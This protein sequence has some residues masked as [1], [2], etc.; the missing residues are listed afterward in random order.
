MKN[1]IQ[2]LPETL[3]NQ[4][5]AGEVVER[6]ASVVK[7]L[8]ENAVDAGATHIQV[9]ISQAGRSS[10]RIIDNGQGMSKEDLLL[11][12]ERHATSKI[13]EYSD[14]MALK[15]M[16]FRGEALPS[17][18]AV[19]RMTITTVAEGELS[20][21]RLEI[22]GGKK[23]GLQEI[24]GPAGSTI[25]VVDLFY[26][27]PARMAF[28]KSPRVEWNQ[29][30]T[31]LERVALGFPLLRFELLHNGKKIFQLFPAQEVI[32]R[33][34]DLWGPEICQNLIPVNFSE[35]RLRITGFISPPHLHHNTARYIAF[36][37]N[38]RW[39][40]SPLLYPLILRNYAGMLPSGRF[41]AAILWLDV[42][43]ELIDINIHPFKQ[44]VRF[45][46]TAWIQGLTAKALSQAIKGHVPKPTPFV[47]PLS[48][49]TWEDQTRQPLLFKESSWIHENT[50]VFPDGDFEEQ[51][52][53]H[54]G[55][56]R[57][58]ERTWSF[59]DSQ[60]AAVS[61]GQE[62]F[63]NLPIIAQ[64][65]GTYL[66][67]SL[68]RGLILIDQHA[69]HERVLF[70]RFLAQWR[71][72]AVSSQYLMIPV[73]I[74][75]P[76]GLMIE[77]EVLEKECN[78]LGFEVAPAGGNNVWLKSIPAE[79]NIHQ[80][81][82]AFREIL[83]AMKSGK[84]ADNPESRIEPLVK[85]LACHSAIRA[86]QTLNQEE[87]LSLLRQLD[88]TESPSH[89]PHGRPLWLLISWDELEKRFKRK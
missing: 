15:T 58:T 83:E 88:Q 57:E 70:E 89:C 46:Q 34:T 51:N 43:P 80:A 9:E 54:V 7:E 24:A 31:A 19:S 86:G 36:L 72:G 87:I 61:A 48:T 64:L 79:M 74:E 11:A 38:Q 8:L 59:H 2:L 21:H 40:R 4:I 32:L 22:W 73:L 53:A 18:A 39:V 68:E 65:Q 50:P 77:A 17:I 26:N 55:E 42:P 20:G 44:E 30:Q 27:T 81:E 62:G 10:I 56:T 49:S 25:D 60:G 47:K 23:L 13:K 52:A 29:I 82:E 41:P 66:L 6:P 35:D 84:P 69:A 16:G 75:L 37:V 78:P 33:I 28:L 1:T 12:V 67:G 85:L 45:S 5:A 71:S 3:I 63:S 76:P 14:L